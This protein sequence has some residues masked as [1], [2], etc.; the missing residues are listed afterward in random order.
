MRPCFVCASTSL[1]EHREPELVAHWIKQARAVAEIPM[2]F[3]MPSGEPAEPQ[4]KPRIV[5]R[6]IG[7]PPPKKPIQG[8]IDWSAINSKLNNKGRGG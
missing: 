8:Q 3:R 4:D 7:D 2:S 5:R 6:V 1:C